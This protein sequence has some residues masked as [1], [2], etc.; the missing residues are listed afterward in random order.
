MREPATLQARWAIIAII[1]IDA[2]RRFDAASIAIEW[3][4]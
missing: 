4:N 1:E 2:D 3:G